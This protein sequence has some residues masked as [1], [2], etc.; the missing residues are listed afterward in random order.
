[1]NPLKKFFKK[2][3]ARMI[4]NPFG[5]DVVIWRL[6]DTAWIPKKE[7]GRLRQSRG[8]YWMEFIEHSSW[9]KIKDEYVTVINGVP[10]IFLYQVVQGVY[11]P[12][13]FAADFGELSPEVIRET[14][15]QLTKAKI[16]IAPFDNQMAEL[17]LEIDKAT[18]VKDE[19]RISEL[20]KNIDGIKDKKEYKEILKSGEEA[21]KNLQQIRAY[22]YMPKE[23]AKHWYSTKLEE[24]YRKYPS[25]SDQL[26]KM[27]LPIGLIIIL[28]VL[29]MVFSPKITEALG[30]LRNLG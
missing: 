19:T 7:Q 15:Q 4:G 9:K 3:G 6:H 25:R 26:K 18:K 10:M 5:I 11:Q 30:G 27:I 14:Q 29:L 16:D 20:T 1:M 12:M 8:I 21:F 24:T 17:G 28:F 13:K 2:I 23:E 22:F